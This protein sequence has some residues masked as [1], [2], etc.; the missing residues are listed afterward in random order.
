MPELLPARIDDKI[1]P[2]ALTGCWIW[3]GA[4]QSSGYGNLWDGTRFKR[5]HRFV[6]ERLIG[7]IPEGMILCHRC[8]NRAC[9]NPIHMFIGDHKTNMRDMVAKGRSLVGDLNPMT[10]ARLTV[11]FVQDIRRRYLEGGVTQKQLSV[12]YKVTP[13]TISAIVL[14]KRWQHVP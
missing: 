3:W 12:I 11:Q 8:D 6:W 5:A 10:N 14:R 4:I 13:Q 7:E 9:V 1:I 2:E